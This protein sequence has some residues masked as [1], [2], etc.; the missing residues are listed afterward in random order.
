MNRLLMTLIAG[1]AAAAFSAVASAHVGLSVSIGEPGFYGQINV[2]GFPPPEVIYPRPIV[3]APGP[4]YGP[5]VYLRVPPGWQRHWAEHCR[6]YHAC[7]RRVYF[8]RD[9]WYQREYAPRYREQHGWAR[10]DEHWRHRD[11]EG[12]RRDWRR[13]DDGRRHYDDRGGDN[14]GSD[15][16]G[17]RHD[18]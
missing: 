10:G 3:V 17:W 7:G 11:R 2:G 8:V 4:V 6:F 1:V 5:P 9:S 12:D 13:G 14:P 16:P 18:R 15:G